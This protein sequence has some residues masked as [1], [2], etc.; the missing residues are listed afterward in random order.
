MSC[1]GEMPAL[2]FI[3]WHCLWLYI[4]TLGIW[5]FF[6]L[7]IFTTLRAAERMQALAKG[8][9]DLWQLSQSEDNQDNKY[10]ETNFPGSQAKSFSA[11][12]FSYGLWKP[13]SWRTILRSAFPCSKP[14]K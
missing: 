13:V 4:I 8:S 10:Y 12:T 11:S 2:S 3:R 5:L 9:A 1:R 7:F 14:K 6:S